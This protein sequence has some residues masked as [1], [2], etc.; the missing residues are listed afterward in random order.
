MAATVPK[1]W[2]RATDTEYS[3]RNE[4]LEDAA[5]Q[6][7]SAELEKGLMKVIKRGASQ[8]YYLVIRKNRKS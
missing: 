1:G 7:T 8:P 2:H 3:T 4:A 6:F 5:A